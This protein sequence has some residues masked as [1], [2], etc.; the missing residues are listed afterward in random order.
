MNNDPNLFIYR[1]LSEESAEMV[2]SLQQSYRSISSFSPI[3]DPHLTLLS[4]Q[5]ADDTSFETLVT[6][7][8]KGPETSEDSLDL[9]IAN[10]FIH[11]STRRAGQ[12]AIGMLLKGDL[13]ETVLDE[14]EYLTA[15]GERFCSSIKQRKLRPHV[16]IGYLN[17]VQA[18][19]PI[20]RPVK[21]CVE[22]PVSLLPIKSNISQIYA[23]K[24]IR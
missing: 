11:K 15:K 3:A 22:M 16:T 13:L 19:N 1:P 23:F 10:S 18:I 7:I 12:A 2:R 4:G 6:R 24:P 8:K 21:D 14:H 20:M 9:S 17:K 5:I